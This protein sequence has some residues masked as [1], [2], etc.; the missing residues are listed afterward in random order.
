[1]LSL[2]LLEV[3][4]EMCINCTMSENYCKIFQKKKWEQLKQHWQNVDSLKLGCGFMRF[5]YTIML[6]YMFDV[7]I[8]LFKNKIYK[9]KKM[10]P[11]CNM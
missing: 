7:S 3:Y 11:K 1:M 4:S 5:H 10:V 8:I 6:L 9:G 2:Y